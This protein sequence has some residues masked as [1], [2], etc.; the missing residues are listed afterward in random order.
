MLDI[1][2]NNIKVGFAS[3]PFSDCG[4]LRI[5]KEA[6]DSGLK[7]ELHD[8][9]YIRVA[10][11]K[12]PSPAESG[13]II[14]A[15]TMDWFTDRAPDALVKP[16]LPFLRAKE[17][18]LRGD[19]ADLLGKIGHPEALP[20]LQELNQDPDPEVAEAAKEAIEMIV[21]KKTM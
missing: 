2:G 13:V 7:Q 21:Q 19:I 5:S 15:D 8:E 12:G 16:L 6:G 1:R 18:S 20:K 17:A 9:V 3:R 10:A 11:I 4:E 14:S